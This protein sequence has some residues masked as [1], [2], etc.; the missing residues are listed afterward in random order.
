MQLEHLNLVV[1]DI[2]RALN[3]YRA[4]FPHWHVRGGGG[5]D[6]YGKPRRW[7]HFGDDRHYLCFNDDGEG[8]NRDLQGHQTGL[9]HFAYVTDNLDAVI[10]RLAAAGFT[11]DKDGN[12]T[13]YR[14]N[15]YFL[16]PDGFEVEFVQYLADEPALRNDYE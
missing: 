16:D 3:F 14:R 8:I 4:A 11:P 5:G 10:A 6:W 2:D 1:Q 15:C 12:P 9:A 7:V 13:E